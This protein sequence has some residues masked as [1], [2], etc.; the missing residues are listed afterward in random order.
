MKIKQIYLIGNPNSGKTS[1]FNAITGEKLK[2]G[3]WPGVTVE[4]IEGITTFEDTKLVITDLP[5]TYS[6]TPATPEE[7]IVLDSISEASKGKILNVVDISNFERNLLLTTQLVELGIK[8]VLSLN[9]YD[10]FTKNGGSIDLQRFTALTK[11]QAF[12]T[13]ARSSKGISTL[14][15]ALAKDESSTENDNGKSCLELTEPWQKALTSL[16]KAR[17]LIF[18]NLNPLEKYQLLSE[19]I[20]PKV[21]AD[22]K[23]LN[24]IREELAKTLSE[25]YNKSVK[26]NALA[27]ELATDR[28]AR[29]EK[30]LC[31]SATLPEKNIPKWQEKIDAVVTHKFWGLPI[32]VALMAFVFWTTFSLAEGPMEWL[33]N[34]VDL[35][36]DF[37]ATKMAPGLLSDLL[38]D[39]IIR[40]VG[41]IL[42]FVPNILILFFWIALLEDSGYMSRAAFMMDRIM[43][44]MGLQGRAFIPMIMGLGCNV[45]AIM[46][47]RIIDSRF[48]RLLTILLI[49]LVSCAARLPVLVLLCGAFF[50]ENPSMWMFLLFSVNVAV[51]L[52][53]GHFTSALFKV[54]ETSPFLLE[55]PT[56]RLPTPKS[57]FD[58]L[59]SKAW[60]FIEKAGT[61]ILAGIIIIW[62]LTAFPRE[63][64]LSFDYEGELVT[65]Q[66]MVN[67][68]EKETLLEELEN[69]REMELMENRYMGKLGKFMHP[70]MAPLGFSWRE[71]VSLVPGFFAKESVVSTLKVLYLPFSTDLG[72]AMK[73]AG[74]TPVSA[75][76]FML[77]TLLYIP[78]LATFGI[79]WKETCS[80]KFTVGS[81]FVYFIIAYAASFGALKIGESLQTSDGGTLDKVLI[82]VVSIIAILYLISK[83]IAAVKGRMCDTCPSAAS[84]HARTSS[85][86]KDCG[87]CGGCPK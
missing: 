50:P 22:D 7:R 44:S 10:L 46:A 36:A 51:I 73:K 16:V 13:V 63:V 68:E 11:L 17:D 85:S 1:L 9:C 55:M 5:G 54:V 23:A 56:Y 4:K 47:A 19:I 84:C 83:T 80:L 35:L 48:Q 72:E 81:L 18:S 52:L 69:K 3:N 24:E 59:K 12:P 30:L 66:E 39:G 31:A 21:N 67:S 86:K 61:I 43:K 29:I 70:V 38:A 34:M 41:E 32:F 33:E 15:E 71:T 49:P 40:G 77:F 14:I 8:P 53:L 65:I 82:V 57:I 78:C 87:P 28:Y 76:V 2:V 60:H 62:V 37:V 25:K 64:P 58:T 45:P 26:P 75:F 20:Q 74:T 42:T 79:M 27:C 6:L